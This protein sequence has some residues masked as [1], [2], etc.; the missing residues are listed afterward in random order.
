MNMTKE[1]YVR[2]SLV[3]GFIYGFILYGVF[4]FTNLAIFK[5]FNLKTAVIDMAWGGA[6]TASALLITNKIIYDQ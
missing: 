4:D 1:T 5:E 2:D 6:L 3:K